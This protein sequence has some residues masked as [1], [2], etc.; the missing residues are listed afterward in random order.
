MKRFY[1]MKVA[2]RLIFSFTVVLI[3]T[4]FIG[5]W[6]IFNM[7]NID[8][9]YSRNEVE[10][11]KRY[12][13]IDIVKSNVYDMRLQ[14]RRV[15]LVR[16]D[17]EQVSKIK[18]NTMSIV[19]KIESGLIK[20]KDLFSNEPQYLDDI[21]TAE[22]DIRQ[23]KAIIASYFD[24]IEGQSDQEIYEKLNEMSTSYSD[25]LVLSANNMYKNAGLSLAE[26]SEENSASSLNTVVVT[27]IFVGISISLGTLL[28]VFLSR[29]IGIPLQN[30]IVVSE[31]V[32]KGNLEINAQSNNRDELG[33]L[34]NGFG[35]VVDTLRRLL[36]DINKMS[37]EQ[38]AGEIDHR[39]DI[40]VY[41][42]GYKDVAE[43]INSMM[44]T[45]ASDVFEILNNLNAYGD[46]NFD[47]TIKEFPKKK[48]IITESLNNLCNNLK[49]ISNEIKGLVGAA[50]TGDLSKNINADKYSGDWKNIV[51]Q[52]NNLLYVIVEPIREAGK[53]L[54][55]MSAG[56]LKVSMKGNYKGE[57]S[58]LKE[59]INSTILQLNVYIS[60][61]S[62]ILGELSN[63]NYDLSVTGEY[64]GDFLPI[65]DGLNLI[66]ERINVVMSDIN[67]SADQV[68]SGARLISNSSM[69]LSQ[70]ATMQASAVQELNST[71]ESIA[72][73]TKTAANTA[74][75]AND[76]AVKVQENAKIG[77]EEMKTMLVAMEDINLSSNN[78]SKIIKVIE[79]IA[80]QTNLLALNAAV[81]AA[82][83]GQHG[84]GFAVVADQ[85]RTLA[86][87][88]QE[89]AKE[90]TMLIEG[91]VDKVA[92]GTK[93]AKRTAG[94]LEKIVS[95]ITDISGLVS[96]IAA[97]SAKQAA[98]ITQVNTGIGQ[99]ADVTQA[100]TATSEEEA[101]SS[102][103]LSSQAETFRNMVGMFKLKT[104]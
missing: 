40:S 53:V 26:T 69:S 19:Q 12:E 25:A 91:S 92:E 13:A 33:A 4:L 39:I 8:S 82:R 28:L 24:N 20:C 62:D 41:E 56:N 3:F 18:E 5:L 66:I 102:Q 36:S 79:E 15:V 55:D 50:S 17:P 93:I 58:E 45:T 71:I 48:I 34:T 95:G 10:V 16:N 83:A 60:D 11:L 64:A 70:G 101:S 78:I 52:L 38:K 59:A 80:L 1:N 100:N 23:F 14:I 103:Q 76:L 6:C 7:V 54:A 31:A 32:A 63:D 87:R 96:E 67:S 65:K 99:I 97:S 22:S 72:E 35:A 85:V 81:E 61:I 94:A 46:G 57:F 75:Q 47:I 86:G 68:A 29:S 84:R 49:G 51:E 104:R 74:Q 77:N 43:G 30:L 9:S 42:G 89:A 90:T 27:A 44:E 73:Q 88:S 98:S 37:L 21:N 2:A